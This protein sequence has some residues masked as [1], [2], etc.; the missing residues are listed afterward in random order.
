MTTNIPNAVYWV[1]D[2]E[3]R[4]PGF[5]IGYAECNS[6]WKALIAR[7]LDVVS[8]NVPNPEDFTFSH[9]K[10][11][12]GFLDIGYYVSEEVSDEIRDRIDEVVDAVAEES[13]TICEI[14]GNP[15]EFVR[16]GGYVMVRCKELIEETDVLLERSLVS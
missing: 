16:R 10:E 9:I 3:A 6:G 12:W 14:T 2:L 5:Q 15:G 11:K 7:V 4:Y 8:E 13:K 1:D